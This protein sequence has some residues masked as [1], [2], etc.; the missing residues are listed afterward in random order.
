MSKISL[1]KGQLLLNSA[2]ENTSTK[3]FSKYEEVLS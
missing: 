2:L 1:H 3:L